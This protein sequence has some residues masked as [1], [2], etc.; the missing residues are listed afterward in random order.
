[1]FKV[2]DN[3]RIHQRSRWLA[4]LGV[5]YSKALMPKCS[6]PSVATMGYRE[7]TLLH[8]F[9][10]YRV[11]QEHAEVSCCHM[12][13]TIDFS[14]PRSPLHLADVQFTCAGAIDH[15]DPVSHPVTVGA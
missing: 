6:S 12:R 1:M 14:V 13:C 10:P 9:D 8:P 4:V 2:G 11:C 15:I 3:F 7:P 5:H